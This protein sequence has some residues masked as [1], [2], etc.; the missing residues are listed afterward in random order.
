MLIAVELLR[1]RGILATGA[2][3]TD[4]P[5][6]SMTDALAAFPATHVLLSLPPEKESYWLERDLLAKAQALTELPVTQVI[7]PSTPPPASPI[8][9]THTPPT[10]PEELP[11]APSNGRNRQTIQSGRAAEAPGR[12]E[13]TS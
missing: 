5:L 7:V 3:G 1:G 9:R 2:V 13:R 6:E 4:K 12:K 10:R 8:G 11:V